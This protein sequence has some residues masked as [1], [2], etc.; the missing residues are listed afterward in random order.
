MHTFIHTEINRPQRK[1]IRYDL[2]YSKQLS[3]L[4][5]SSEGGGLTEVEHR[6]VGTGALFRKNVLPRGQLRGTD[7]Q[8]ERRAD[9]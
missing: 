2:T 9:F 8:L 4:T 6:I 7:V 3:S 5:Q 1:Q